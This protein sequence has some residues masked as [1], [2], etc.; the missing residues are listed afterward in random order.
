MCI[1]VDDS[2]CCM[3][4]MN[5]T[6]WINYNKKILRKFSHPKWDL[7]AQSPVMIPVPIISAA[8]SA[9][10]A[11]LLL[12]VLSRHP[13]DR[14]P[15]VPPSTKGNFLCWSL[16]T[17]PTMSPFWP[18][19]TLL[20][21]LLCVL[22]LFSVQAPR[23]SLVAQMVKNL[24]AMQEM[25]VWSLGWENP[26]EKGMATHSNNPSLENP[27]GQR[28]LAGYSPQ[29][30]KES[31]TTEQLSTVPMVLSWNDGFQL[32]MLIKILWGSFLKKC[33]CLSPTCLSKLIICSCVGADFSIIK[34]TPPLPVTLINSQGV[35]TTD[36]ETKPTTIDTQLLSGQIQASLDSTIR[37]LTCKMT[38][39]AVFKLLSSLSIQHEFSLSS[40]V[41]RR[42]LV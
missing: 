5:T 23:V 19:P 22:S 10:S 27:H 17:F 36:L 12:Q 33:T 42:E 18:N 41:R 32:W 14:I 9:H 1:C 25:H 37:D 29:S 26:L 34:S 7:I 24:P 30:C 38:P 8:L 39:H 31:D 35:W 2:L 4:E 3:P 6:F 28:S 16:K 13:S 40:V 15:T 11:C 21:V 20:F